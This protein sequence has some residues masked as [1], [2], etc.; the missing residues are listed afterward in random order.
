MKNDDLKIRDVRILSLVASQSSATMKSLFESL[1]QNHS[2]SA[3]SSFYSS[4]NRLNSQGLIYRF[5]GQ[6]DDRGKTFVEITQA[7][8]DF[9]KHHNR[10]LAE[11]PPDSLFVRLAD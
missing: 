4:C 11:Q 1:V 7:G 2:M 8:I 3:R 10:Q 5:D 9:L 6:G